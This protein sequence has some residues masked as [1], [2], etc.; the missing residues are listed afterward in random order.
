MCPPLGK[1]LLLWRILGDVGLPPHTQTGLGFKQFFVGDKYRHGF[2]F[3]DPQ[4]C[5]N[6]NRI[7]LFVGN[8]FIQ[9]PFLTPVRSSVRTCESVCSLVL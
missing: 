2:V 8:R 9:Q 5:P 1:E 4:T 7:H 3:S 6:T